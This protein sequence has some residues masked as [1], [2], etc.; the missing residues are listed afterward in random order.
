MNRQPISLTLFCAAILVLLG[1]MRAR[2]D[3]TVTFGVTN[4]LVSAKQV[5]AAVVPP[6]P[7]PPETPQQLLCR[8]LA[9]PYNTILTNGSVVLCP[10]GA[11]DFD[12]LYHDFATNMPA[13]PYTKITFSNMDGCYLLT[14][15]DAIQHYMNRLPYEARINAITNAP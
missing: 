14:Q 4:G 3:V 15:P 10:Q 11:V 7:D 12:V 9:S 2:G 1:L 8:Q 13:P 5:Q 6:F